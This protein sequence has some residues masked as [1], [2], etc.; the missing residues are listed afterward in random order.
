MG[1]GPSPFF[2]SDPLGFS[3]NYYITAG[4]EGGGLASLCPGDSGGP[5]F[6]G[7][8]VPYTSVLGINAYYFFPPDDAGISSVN[9]FARLDSP[10]ASSFIASTMAKYAAPKPLTDRGDP[11]NDG[12]DPMASIFPIETVSLETPGAPGCTGVI[13]TENS[14]LTAAHCNVGPTTIAHFY[15]GNDSADGGSHVPFASINASSSVAVVTQGATCD[16]T[17]T[18]NYP[19]SC[20]TSSGST[21]AYHDAD[22]AVLTLASGVP[23]GFNPVVLG[24]RGLGLQDA[25]TP[26]V[27]WELAAGGAMPINA[28]SPLMW[29]PVTRLIDTSGAGESQGWFLISS[30]YG[31]WNDAGGPVFQAPPPLDGGTD[32]AGASTDMILRGIV[33][34]I[35]NCSPGAT[36][37][38]HQNTVVSVTFPDN[39]DWLVH[40]GGAPVSAVAT[41]GAGH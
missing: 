13:L 26:P 8:L 21:G 3:R 23:V 19:S 24:P 6:K 11:V 35:G 36:V 37:C 22:L 40:L 38:F 16:P 33:V 1:G 28:N 29:A 12:S 20:F 32:D 30:L 4:V 2:V 17:D 7:G 27:W 14:I 5:L 34:G 9:V 18:A 31:M 39:Y 25:G 15:L 41:F 10:N